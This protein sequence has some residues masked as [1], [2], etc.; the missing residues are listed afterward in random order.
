MRKLI[1]QIP[2]YNEAESLPV[3]LAALP[4]EVEGFDCVEWLVVDDGSSDD[5]SA[6]AR[7]HGV[8]HIERHVTNLGLAAAFMTGLQSALQAGASVVVNTDADNQYDARDIPALV[9]PI[10][11]GEALM[12]IGAR[13]INDIADFS[14]TKRLLQKLGS[15]TVRM[16]S[17]TDIEDA[18]SGMRAIHRDAAVRL[19]VFNNYTYT[20]ETIIQ[21]GRS[22]IPVRS[23]PVRTNPAMRESRLVKSIPSYIYRSVVTIVRVFLVYRPLRAFGVVAV[24][25]GSLGLLLGLRYLF[26]AWLGEGAGHIQSVIVMAMLLAGAGLAL[27]GGFVGDLIAANRRLLQDMRARLLLDQLERADTEKANLV[28]AEARQEAL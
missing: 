18:P 25:L 5:T 26:Y 27:L 17:D 20:L 10:I 11:D 2:C 15:W 14:K 9:K 19:F 6:V 24:V 23:V 7:A 13:P 16:V 28:S 4:R 3:A 12:V 21:G 22:N 1:I 8:D